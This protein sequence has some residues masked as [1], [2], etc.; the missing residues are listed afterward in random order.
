LSNQRVLFL[1]PRWERHKESGRTDGRH[2]SSR[3]F[4][5]FRPTR[6]PR[7]GQSVTRNSPGH[8]R[9]LPHKALA[10]QHPTDGWVPTS[11]PPTSHAPIEEESAPVTATA[12]PLDS[13]SF[14]A[15]RALLLLAAAAAASHPSPPLYL[16]PPSTK[17]TCIASLSPPI[18]P[19]F[20]TTACSALFCSEFA[21]RR[22]GDEQ[23]FKSS[24]ER[25]CVRACVI[26]R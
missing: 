14:A 13:T 21:R 4:R 6:F 25:A 24:Q 10:Y 3:P 23:L 22:R 2:G 15:S 26:D 16:P 12:M 9:H 5:H 17:L 20:T 8:P 1:F 11:S 19:P 7:T 18:H